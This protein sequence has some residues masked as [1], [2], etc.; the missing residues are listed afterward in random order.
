MSPR[1]LCFVIMPFG[2]KPDPTGRADIDFNKVY[3]MALEPAIEAAGGKFIAR[4]VAAQ[5]YESGIKERTTVIEFDSLEAAIALHDGPAYQAALEALGD[6]V[7]RDL[8]LVE[9]AE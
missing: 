5:V 2:T 8:R 6:G 1:P 3:E 4:G 7:V 9:A